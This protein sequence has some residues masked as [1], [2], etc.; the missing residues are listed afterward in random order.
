[1]AGVFS[2][3]VAVRP[4]RRDFL[5]TAFLGIGAVNLPG[6]LRLRAESASARSP[7]ET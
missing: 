4:D 3:S 6:I 5:R 1:M 7:N 2:T